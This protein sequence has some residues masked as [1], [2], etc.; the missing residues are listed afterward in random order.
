MDLGLSGQV[1]LVTGGSRGIGRAIAT[2]L[3]REG[4]RVALLARD[5]AALERTRAELA[6]DSDVIAVSADT[7]DQAAVDAAVGRVVEAFG[8]IDV[9]V[10]AAATPASS[11][12]AGPGLAGA[13]PGEILTQVDTKVLGYLRVIRAAVPHLRAAGGGRIVNISGMNARAT[14]AIGGSIRNIGVVALS[15]NLADELGKDNIAVTVVHP[16]MT[17]TERVFTDAMEEQSVANALGRA[18][19]AAEVADLVT[20]L[21]SPRAAA[22]NGAVVTA[23][24]GRVGPLFA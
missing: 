24:G 17:R 16:G 19:D 10:N 1:A 7:T 14:G 8:R 15:K 18:I 20:F 12:G 3:A 23:D 11:T 6:G 2:Q 21:A 9:V 5:E 4:A 22:A 13:D